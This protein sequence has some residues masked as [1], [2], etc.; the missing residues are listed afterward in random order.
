MSYSEITI[1]MNG[2]DITSSLNTNTGV[3]SVD[4]VTGTIEVIYNTQS[5]PE[6]VNEWYYSAV[7]ANVE[8]L[9]R[10]SITSG[11]GF[12]N[13][14]Q[15]TILVG[16]PVNSIRFKAARAGI[17]TF[18]KVDASYNVTVVGQHDIIE[19]EV[20]KIVSCK[21]NSPVTLKSGEKLIVHAAGVSKTSMSSTDKGLFYWCDSIE[22][23]IGF[24]QKYPS[25]PNNINRHMLGI[26]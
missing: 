9:T 7:P 11:V 14:T 19:S 10:E 22:D 21:L 24:Y 8:K 5:S 16:K 4:K 1:R 17:I 25:Q 6:I 26:D 3:V 2:S 15:E 13:G 12:A 20:G 23:G 18:G